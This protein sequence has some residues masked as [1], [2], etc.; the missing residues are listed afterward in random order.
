MMRIYVD[1]RVVHVVNIHYYPEQQEVISLRNGD[2]GFLWIW[3][4]IIKCYL[5]EFDASTGKTF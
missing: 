5:G 4:L 1:L 3:I 2:A